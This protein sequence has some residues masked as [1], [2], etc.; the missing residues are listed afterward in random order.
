MQNKQRMNISIK[1]QSRIG[2]VDEDDD[3]SDEDTIDEDGEDTIDE[4]GD[5]DTKC[6]IGKTTLLEIIWKSYKS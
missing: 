5:E 1:I 4:D 3:L 6:K 2:D